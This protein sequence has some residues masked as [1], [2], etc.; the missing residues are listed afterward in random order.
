MAEEPAGDNRG[1]AQIQIK[2]QL[3]SSTSASLNSIC[4][5]SASPSY[6]PLLIFPRP[7]L[8]GE[9]ASAHPGNAARRE[10]GQRGGRR[11]EV[12]GERVG[13]RW[14]LSVWT[15]SRSDIVA[16]EPVV[17]MKCILL[18]LPRREREEE[19]A[20]GGGGVGFCSM[21]GWLRVVGYPLLNKEAYP[22]TGTG[23]DVIVS[24]FLKVPRCEGG[25]PTS[26]ARGTKRQRREGS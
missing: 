18:S 24:E 16:T 8:S 1:R 6:L 25:Q 10:E 7:D 2:C 20:G 21:A 12:D 17:S 19:E 5:T 9:G 4:G 3:P 13:G 22:V 14:D 15:W 23:G 11:E 26:E